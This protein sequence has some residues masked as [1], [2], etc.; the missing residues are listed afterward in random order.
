MSNEKRYKSPFLFTDHSLATQ[1]SKPLFL[2]L[3]KFKPVNDDY[4]HQIGD[5]LLVAVAKRLKGCVRDRDLVARLG[6]DEFIIVLKD[7]NASLKAGEQVAKNI[8]AAISSPFNISD[9]KISINTSIGIALYPEHAKD[10]DSLI[11]LADNAMYKSKE[12][13]TGC[14]HFCTDNC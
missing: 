13:G 14:F 11:T 8:I 7:P 4:G 2:D 12:N 3:D 9:Q 1:G 10:A 5:D 6:G